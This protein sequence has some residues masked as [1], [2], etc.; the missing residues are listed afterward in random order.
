[1]RHA[2]RA[3]CA[4]VQAVQIRELRCVRDASASRVPVHA[5]LRVPRIVCVGRPWLRRVRAD[6]VS[7]HGARVCRRT[8]CA[9]PAGAK[10]SANTWRETRD[11]CPRPQERKLNI[12]WT[13]RHERL[14]RSQY[15]G[16]EARRARCAP[17]PCEGW[18]A[19][20]RLHYPE[21]QELDRF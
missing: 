21:E 12:A 17:P 7:A 4:L 20:T 14:H 9:V 5:R 6:S 13:G 15:R 1:T 2:A 11:D 8:G 10:G 3:E 16:Q 19:V 18:V